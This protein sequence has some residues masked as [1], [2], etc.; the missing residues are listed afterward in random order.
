MA[1]QSPPPDDGSGPGGRAGLVPIGPAPGTATLSKA[2]KTFNR[3]IAQIQERRQQLAAW[4]A[5]E[6]TFQRLLAQEVEPLERRCDELRLDLLRCFDAAHHGAGTTKAERKKLSALIA[7]LAR[8]LLARSDDPALL[9][10]HDRHSPVSHAQGRR[11]DAAWLQSMAEDVLGLP[12]DAAGDLATPQDL[13][14]AMLRQAGQERAAAAQAQAGADPGPS[15][16]RARARQARAAAQAQEASGSLRE[17]Y[18][19]LASAL[20]PDREPDAAER[21]RKTAWMQRA[22][23]A[24]A[25]KD[26]LA[27]LELQIEAE[28]IDRSRVGEIDEKRLRRYLRVLQEQVRELDQ[29]L[30][31]VAQPFAASLP[32]RASLAP[33]PHAVLQALQA[34]VAT[35]RRQVAAIRADLAAFRDPRALKAWLRQVRVSRA[36]RDDL[37]E[38]FEQAMAVAD[39]VQR[40]GTRRRP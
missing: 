31:A 12:A 23:A 18:R 35:L 37:D 32:A 11:E 10:L 6:P 2:Q 28:Q 19:K 3:L 27:L 25:R 26:L 40:C 20:H 1:R 24:Y 21:A 14:D 5:F 30:R 33:T 15:A 17:V 34:D 16:A 39:G 9:D 13:L 36:A 29:E 22:N 4:Q 8:E 7:D 38:M